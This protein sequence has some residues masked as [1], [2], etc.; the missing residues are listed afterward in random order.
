MDEN[1]MPAAGVETVEAPTVENVVVDAPVTVTAERTVVDFNDIP[2]ASGAGMTQPEM[3]VPE[4][5]APQPEVIVPQS[6]T[7]DQGFAQG[8]NFTASQDFTANQSFAQNQGFTQN[9]GFVQDQNFTQNQ[10]FVQNQGFAQNQ[11]FAPNQGYMPNP[12]NNAAPGYMNNAGVGY[13]YGYNKDILEYGEASA[14]PEGYYSNDPFSS[15]YYEDEDDRPKMQSNGKAIASMILGISSLL[16]FFSCIG[17]IPGIIAIPLGISGLSTC[18]SK[19]MA[20]AGMITGILGTVGGLSY[21][22]YFILNE[23][24]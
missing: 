10:G 1:F 23:I 4:Q 21:L 3:P 24:I 20:R 13:D 7:T 16:M 9:Q 5:V 6:V 17:W 2:M 15:Y 22:M 19:G 18:R 14:M 8:Q 12:G 11:S